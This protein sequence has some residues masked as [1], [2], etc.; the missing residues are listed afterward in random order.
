[1]TIDLAKLKPTKDIQP[2][3]IVLYGPPKIGKTTFAASI[4][5]NLMLDVEG[6]SG[7]VTVSRVRKEEL[8]NFGAVMDILEQL[9]TKEHDFAAV[10]ID[11]GDWFEALLFEAAAKEHGKNSISDVPYGAGFATAQNLWRQFLEALDA[12]RLHKG[13][14]PLIVCHEQ[15]K[16]YANPLTEN[17]DRF[18]LKLRTND[19]GASSESIVK[20]WADCL[21]FVNKQTFVRKEKDGMKETKKATTSDQVFLHTKESPAFLAG[22]RFGLPDKIPFDWPSLSDALSKAMTN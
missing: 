11:S 15:I 2:P 13:I 18:G 21:L 20:E 16:T 19:K 12:L 9:Y 8:D 14:M 3:R 6:G 5:N 22:N 7:A 10:T 1:M 4:P 17:Y